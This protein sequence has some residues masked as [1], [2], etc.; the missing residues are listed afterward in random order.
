MRAQTLINGIGGKLL[1]TLRTVEV[2]AI[3]NVAEIEAHLDSPEDVYNALE[4]EIRLNRSDMGFYVAFEPSYF[5]K[6]GH[7]FEPYVS[8]TDSTHVERKQLGTPHHDYF[9]QAWYKKG[10]NLERGTGYLSD[11]YF[12]NAGGKCILCSYI[13]PVFD[14]KGHRVGV[15]G[16]DVN[17]DW[18]KN[19]IAYEEEKVKSASLASSDTGNPDEDNNYFFVQ[20]LDSKGKKIAGSENFD[21]KTIQAILMQDD[22]GFKEM[23]TNGTTY[24]VSTKRLKQN[25][26]TLV[27]AQHK[28]FVLLYGYVLAIVIV[29]LMVISNIVIIFLISHGIKSAVRPLLF[30]SDSAQEVARGNFDTPLPTFKHKDEISQLRDSFDSMQQSLKRYVTELQASTASKASIESELNVAHSIQMSMLPKT[31]PPFPERNDIELYAM[32]KPAKA[33]GGDLY[34]FFLRDD[35]LF[36]CIGDVSVKGVPASLVMAVTRTLFRNVGAHVAEPH[37]IV[38]TMNN[39]ICEGNDNSMFVTLFVGE[40]NLKNGLLRYC[41][42]GH[43]APYMIGK[44]TLACDANLPV[45]V[46]ADFNYTVQEIQM[47][48]GTIIFLYTDGL[49]EAET[50]SHEQ[51]GEERIEHIVTSFSGTPQQLIET[52]T[53]AVQHFVGD[54][55]QSDDLTMLAIQYT[56]PAQT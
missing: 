52:M 10:L 24:M 12:D 14:R 43:D 37:L 20:V 22:I 44:G 9:E 38:E 51:F 16:R 17:L 21:D 35:R 7:W 5:P 50:H 40:L 31:F 46:L 6:E 34:D 28:D 32:Q 18:L 47:T 39:A 27:V 33:V 29:F 2:T 48:P 42:A 25:G 1:T 23:E 53:E 36:F 26:W 8:F 55:E 19:T 13:M 30:L 11:P 3:N 56:Q 45:G 15:Y 54:T 4:H 41:N 49:N